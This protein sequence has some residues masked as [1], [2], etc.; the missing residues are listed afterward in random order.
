MAP[1]P[2]ES[3]RLTV[4]QEAL[5]VGLAILERAR[6][7]GPAEVA[8]VFGGPEEP[9]ARLR[10]EGDGAARELRERLDRLQPGLGNPVMKVQ[11]RDIPTPEEPSSGGSAASEATER[12]ELQQALS[13]ITTRLALL[14]QRLAPQP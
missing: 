12:Q 6:R 9:L 3:L 1:D 2:L 10:Q 5:P 13:R 14:E 4:M 11:V 7:G 8:E